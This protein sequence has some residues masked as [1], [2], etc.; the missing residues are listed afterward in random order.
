VH[1]LQD[2]SEQGLIEARR[3]FDE[4]LRQK[5]PKRILAARY[6]LA[7]VALR[8]HAPDKAQT[9][10][11]QAYADAKGDKEAADSPL[12][13]SLALD[14]KLAGNRPQ[15]AL[16]EAEAAHE[17][18]PLS[19]GIG[20]QYVRALIAVGRAGD[21]V[22]YL[23]DQVQM[24]RTDPRLQEELARAYAAE[25]KQALQHLALAESYAL[26]DG[27]PAALEQLRIARRAPDATYYDQAII[28]ARERELKA[29]WKDEMKSD[30]KDQ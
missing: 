24:Y 11:Q 27:L 13:E 2:T 14:I 8:Q 19:H 7:F 18:F 29:R 26:D 6:G 4:Q 17:K 22:S 25:G 15:E 21:A 3:V 5:D 10:L 12:L 1:V 30:Q 20:A 9:L 16:K 23:R 28:D